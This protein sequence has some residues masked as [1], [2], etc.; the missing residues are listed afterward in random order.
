[1]STPDFTIKLVY[2][3]YMYKSVYVSQSIIDCNKKLH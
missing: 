2:T 1:M 3:S